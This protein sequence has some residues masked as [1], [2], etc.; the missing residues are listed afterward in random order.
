MSS[1]RIDRWKENGYTI[2]RTLSTPTNPRHGTN[3][4]TKY[5]TWHDCETN[6]LIQEDHSGFSLSGPLSQSFRMSRNFIVPLEIVIQTKLR[7][8]RYY[9]PT[10]RWRSTTCMEHMDIHFSNDRIRICKLLSDKKKTQ[11]GYQ[12]FESANK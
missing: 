4:H 6:K 7:P 10:P 5:I 3:D 11:F 12:D 9:Q 2:S 8:V 1:L